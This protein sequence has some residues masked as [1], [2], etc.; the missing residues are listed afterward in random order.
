MARIVIVDDHPIFLTGLCRALGK[1][2]DIDIV[3]TGC[4]GTEALQLVA[5][6]NPDTLVLDIVMPKMNGIEVVRALREKGRDIH[7]LILSSD[8]AEDTI[9]TLVETGIDGFI[10]KQS[11]EEDI[12]TAIRN[13][14]AGYEYYGADIARLIK[15]V[16]NAKDVSDSIFTPRELDIVRLSCKG[17]EY[18]E[19]ARELNIGMRT[20]ETH[21]NNIFRKLGINNT[22]E[23]V[24]YAIREGII[25]V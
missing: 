6:L 18:K 13:V 7:T 23:L 8:T 10:S 11:T 16:K 25:N 12:V 20:V 3:G 24:L 2:P 1:Y 9:G 15:R 4:D 19:I 5:D 14:T 21:K 22:V 17:L